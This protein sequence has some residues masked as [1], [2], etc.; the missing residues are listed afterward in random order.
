MFSIITWRVGGGVIKAN[1]RQYAN[2]QLRVAEWD[3]RL[4]HETK[5][6]LMQ[7]YDDILL[8]GGT[9]IDDMPHGTE[10]SD[11]TP[12]KAQKLYNAL[13][14]QDM[15]RRLTAIDRAIDEWTARDPI[16]RMEYI[17]QKFWINRLTPAGIAQKLNIAEV[18]TW[19]WRKGFLTLVGK[20]MGWRV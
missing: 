8:P 14:L 7:A 12:A 20:Y 19:H 17:R 4:Y 9:V 10:T 3:V 5:A 18:T 1:R 15:K 16:L 13:E 6:E 11:P 2:S